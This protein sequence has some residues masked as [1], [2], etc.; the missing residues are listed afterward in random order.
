RGSAMFALALVP[1]ALADDPATPAPET[2]I[3]TYAVIVGTAP[4]EPG[5][6][7]LIEAYL[8][9]GMPAHGDFPKVYAASDLQ[10]AGLTGY[11]LVAALPH[12]KRVADQLKTQLDLAGTPTKVVSVQTADGE[13]L[14]VLAM[15]RFDVSGNGASLFAYDVCLAVDPGKGASP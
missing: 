10:A 9:A 13:N 7:K 3:I 4:D 8:E 6:T 15:D 11:L 1:A 14:R 5:A 2:G 12:D